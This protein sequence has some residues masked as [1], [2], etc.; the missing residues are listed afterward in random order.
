[1]PRASWMDVPR[2]SWMDVLVVVVL[3]K[4]KKIMCLIK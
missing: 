1:V 2:A 4:K 3:E